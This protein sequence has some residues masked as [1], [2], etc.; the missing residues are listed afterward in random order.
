[1]AHQTDSKSRYEHELH[2]LSLEDNRDTEYQPMNPLQPSATQQSPPDAIQQAVRRHFR[3]NG[4]LQILNPWKP[5]REAPKIALHKGR[6]FAIIYFLSVLI[7]LVAAIALIVIN[8]RTTPLGY[9]SPSTVSALQFVA[10]LLDIM[11]QVTLTTLALHLV[12]HRLLGPDPLPFGAVLAPYRVADVSY[13]WSLDL[14][15]S[16]SSP[17]LQGAYKIF[18]CITVPLIILLAAVT[19]PSSAILVIPRRIQYIN[20]EQ[21]VLFNQSSTMFPSVMRLDEQGKLP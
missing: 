12:R 11:M 4:L 18:F 9:V 8:A 5:H 17:T 6:S 13:L 2:N 16:I 3:I 14:W 1:M 19:G 21:L 7:P 10:K 20:N 15:G